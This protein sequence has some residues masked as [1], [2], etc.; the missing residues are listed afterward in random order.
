MAKTGRRLA[1]LVTFLVA[2][3]GCGGSGNTPVTATDTGVTSSTILLGNTIAQS[4]PAAA[5]GTIA[6][7]EAAYFNYVNSSGGINGRTITYKILDDGYNPANTVP[8]TKQLVEQDQVFAMFSGLGTQAQTSVRDYLNGKKV[9]Q[10][11]VATGA[12]TFSKDYAGTLTRWAGSRP[13]RAK[14]GSTRLTCSRITRAPRSACSTRT[15]TT[16]PTI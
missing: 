16:A 11:F 5:Y 12:T 13:T 9:P 7:A 4:G 6:Y 15:T 1:A 10:L 8:L 14:P 2:L 3:A